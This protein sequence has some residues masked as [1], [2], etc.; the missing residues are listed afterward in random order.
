MSLALYAGLGLAAAG[1]SWF[2]VPHLERRLVTR[3]LR[4]LCRTHRWICLTFDDGPSASLTPLL[5]DRLREHE[6]KASFFVLGKHAQEQPALVEAIIAAGHD[7]GGHSLAH[8]NA[9]K[10]LPGAHC[11]DIEEGQR[12]VRFLGGDAHLCRAPYGKRSL[13]SW[14]LMKRLGLKSAWWTIDPKD[15]MH[16]PLHQRAVLQRVK[17]AGGGVVL[18]HDRRLRPAGDAAF[19]H[20][21]Y[22]LSLIDKF[23]RLAATERYRFVRISEILAAR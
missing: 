2:G 19:K 12:V 22:V 21:D 9:W 14:L 4:A 17:R 6:I 10:T 16:V 3:R 1:G 15:A 23:A 11:R 8:L 7:V 5:L 20:G 18:L 13:A